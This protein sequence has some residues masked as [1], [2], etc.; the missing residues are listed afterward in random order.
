LF[1]TAAVLRGRRMVRA[2]ALILVASVSANVMLPFAAEAATMAPAIRQQL[3]M[4]LRAKPGPF[5]SKVASSTRVFGG[6]LVALESRRPPESSNHRALN[7]AALKL[8][9]QSVV[10]G[11][12][13]TAAPTRSVNSIRPASVSLG[14]ANVTGTNPWWTFDQGQ[15]PGVGPFMVNVGSSK[16]L[17]VQAEDFKFKHRWIDLTFKRTYNS[18]SRHDYA[19]SDGSQPS[20]YGNGWTNTFDMHA[21]VNSGQNGYFGISIFDADGARYDYLPADGTGTNF[22]APAGQHGTLT[23]DSGHC[24]YYWTATTGESYQFRTPVTDRTKPCAVTP[25]FASTAGRLVTIYGRN[26]HSQ[27]GFSYVFDGGLSSSAANLNQIGVTIDGVQ[28]ASTLTFADFGA[29]CSPAVKFRLLQSI[30]RPDGSLIYYKYDC[31]GNLTETDQPSNATASSVCAIDGTNCRKERYSYDSAHFMTAAAGPKWSAS[32]QDSTNLATGTNGGYVSFLSNGANGVSSI[33]LTGLMS[34]VVPDGY[35][36]AAF[37][38]SNTQPFIYQVRTFNASASTTTYQ[39]SDGHSTT[40]GYDALDRVTSTSTNGDSA[41][42]TKYDGYD[43]DNNLVYKT[44]FRNKRTDYR[45]DSFG[46]LIATAKPTVSATVNGSTASIRPTKLYAFDAHNNTIAYCDPTWSAKHSANWDGASTPTVCPTGVGS[47]TNAGAQLSSWSDQTGNGF[48]PFG[49]LTDTTG[50]LGYQYHYSYSPASEGGTSGNSNVDFG[51]T[52]SIVG[53]T[54]QQPVDGSSTAPVQTYVYD[55]N[56]NVICRGNSLGVEISQFDNLGRETARGDA[57]DATLTQSACAKT[58]GLPGSAIYSTVAYLPNGQVAT[59]RD[60]GEVAANAPVSYTYDLDGN[61]VAESH[62]FGCPPNV[63]CSVGT[64]LKWYDGADRLIEVLQPHDAS[65]LVNT[66]W[67][68]RYIYDLSQ[69]NSV[70]IGSASGLAHGNAYKTQ[71]FITVA[72]NPNPYW[73]DVGGSFFDSADR[74]IRTYRLPSSSSPVNTST[75]DANGQTGLLTSSTD[76]TSTSTSLTYDDA[77]RIVGR[78]FSGPIPTP[79][80]TLVY[81]PNGRTSQISQALY[82]ILAG[83]NNAYL[84]GAAAQ[85]YTYDDE[86]HMLSSSEPDYGT[87]FAQFDATTLT[88]DY[89]PNGSRKDLSVASR[90][91]S[92]TNLMQYSYRADGKRTRQFVNFGGTSK[93]YSWG[94]TSA[95]RPLSMYD[96]LNNT[97]GNPQVARTQVV[98]RNAVRQSLSAPTLHGAAYDETKL[99]KSSLPAVVTGAGGKANS[100]TVGG[101]SMPD[102]ILRQPSNVVKS[103]TNG[104]SARSTA[105]LSPNTSRLPSPTTYDYDT[106]GRLKDVTYPMGRGYSGLTY[107]PE[108]ELIGY[109]GYNSMQISNAYNNRGEL[110]GQHFFDPGSSTYDP[111]WPHVGQQ[112][113]LGYMTPSNESAPINA[114]T[115]NYFDVVDARAEEVLQKSAQTGQ[116]TSAMAWNIDSDDRQVQNLFSKLSSD[117]VNY[118]NGES[119]KIFDA[120]DH[121]VNFSV[122]KGSFWPDGGFAVQCN[123]NNPPTSTIYAPSNAP[124]QAPYIWGPNGHP[125]VMFGDGVHWDGNSVLFTTDSNGN[126]DDIKVEGMSDILPDG[127][128]VERDRDWSGSTVMSHSAAGYS[129][130]LP[131]NPNHDKCLPKSPPASSPSYV[132]PGT[133]NPSMSFTGQGLV[134]TQPSSESYFDGV[135]FIQGVRNYNAQSGGFSSPDAASGDSA[136]PISQKGFVLDDNDPIGLSDPSGFAPDSTQLFQV[137]PNDGN[138]TNVDNGGDSQTPDNPEMYALFTNDYNFASGLLD[139]ISFIIPGGRFGKAVDAAMA[140]NVAAK[141]SSRILTR[142]LGGKIL[143]S[144]AHHIVAGEAKLAEPARMVLRSFDIG[145]NDAENGVILNQAFHNSLH[146]DNYYLSV[147]AR[148][149][150]LSTREDCIEELSNI[151]EDLLNGWGPR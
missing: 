139:G 73:I 60:P 131:P 33:S 35:S 63:S 61:E 23:T 150:G 37:N 62:H 92:A 99:A 1:F 80:Q 5:P 16:N 144:A 147:N 55:A 91:F 110:T 32:L 66:P 90:A 9:P 13:V 107:D 11:E 76:A 105:T 123:D 126:L 116:T 53:D 51:S 108:S 121:L 118:L 86:G 137:V 151:R 36:T 24:N 102:S 10:V 6:Q 97:G 3:T 81:D 75:Y 31:S 27:L 112:G 26:Q 18:L 134:V 46:N 145:I 106:S 49:E 94:L 79:N 48:E 104:A 130:W 14:A 19:G 124:A 111:N 109:S 103:A 45:Y 64:T 65:D 119:D 125:S 149:R 140:G 20:S 30:S 25:R 87:N 83:P 101:G 67:I 82:Q 2:T 47:P 129:T 69:N 68:N 143:G 142:N 78:S 117:Q 50:P 44:D 74:K 28:A 122:P 56:G 138:Y 21:A 85:T 96:P 133:T 135:N 100:R 148:L 4:A 42:L 98:K 132:E 59:S 115:Y 89:Y 120:Y 136:N 77:G 22:I 95:G 12:S 84:A 34:Y 128:L 38:G 127:E 7:A 43:G 52:T 141:A 72:N 29:S 113:Y 57:D 93:V 88:Y 114:I 146:T 41:T 8:R 15:I 58:A 70:T 40:Y 17:V 54:I 39:D 71:E